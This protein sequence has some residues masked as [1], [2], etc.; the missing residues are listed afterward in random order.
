MEKQQQQQQQQNLNW[1]DVI[2]SSTVIRDLMN[3]NKQ[4]A[5]EIG[6]LKLA[7]HKVI[8]ELDNLKRNKADKI[9]LVDDDEK[10]HTSDKECQ[11][12]KINKKRTFSDL[13]EVPI[14]MSKKHKQSSYIMSD[15][16]NK[17]KRRKKYYT[18][19][20]ICSIQ[21][22]QGNMSINQVNSVSFDSNSFF[23]NSVGTYEIFFTDTKKTII[24]QAVWNNK[25]D[26]VPPHLI[27]IPPH[28]IT[29]P[30]HL[31]TKP[32]LVPL[33]Q[34]VTPPPPNGSK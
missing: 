22:R 26:F 6:I 13:E 25:L 9:I 33:S 8:G 16:V 7:L 12:D 28:L 21:K 19:H 18:N 20:K 31:I 1:N 23:I 14:I 15:G 32:H 29:I 10:E 3:Q 5:S 2:L 30:P 17:I 4:Y 11:N 27:T 34:L 24:V